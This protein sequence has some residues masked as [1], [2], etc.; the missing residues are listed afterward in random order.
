MSCGDFID[1]ISVWESLNIKRQI[2]LSNSKKA[3]KSN[4]SDLYRTPPSY[5]QVIYSN[6]HQKQINPFNDLDSLSSSS[7][8]QKLTKDQTIQV[9]LIQNSITTT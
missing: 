5:E 4:E 9:N 6:E 2:D 1:L 7:N 3:G 8:K